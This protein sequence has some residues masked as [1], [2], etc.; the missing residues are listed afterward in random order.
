MNLGPHSR[1]NPLGLL[2]ALDENKE[3]RGELF[4]DDGQ[5]KGECLERVWPLLAC[6]RFCPFTSAGHSAVGDI[7]PGI[8]V[9]D[10]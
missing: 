7:L 6:K 4:W 2:I 9:A 3:A 1:K 5:S 10:F 8:L